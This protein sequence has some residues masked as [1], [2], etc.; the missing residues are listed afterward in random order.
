M[1][2]AL[3]RMRDTEVVFG[4]SPDTDWV[5]T[6]LKEISAVDALD[7]DLY[8]YLPKN[9]R[10]VL[11]RR[12]GSFLEDDNRRRLER[13][14]ITQIHLKRESIPQLQKHKAKTYLNSLIWE[15]RQD[16]TE[17]LTAA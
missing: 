4:S 3:F 7:F 1:A 6:A 10:F 2:I 13:N 11:Y 12:E 8:V 9:Q 17:S 5:S 14:G 16:H 15:Y